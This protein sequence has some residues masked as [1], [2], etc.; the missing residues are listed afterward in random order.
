MFEIPE[1]LKPSVADRNAILN[2]MFPDTQ[3][4]F[5]DTD[6]FQMSMWA[7]FVEQREGQAHLNDSD[8]ESEAEPQ[9]KKSK[10]ESSLKGKSSVIDS[11]EDSPVR[12][13]EP[14][15]KLQSWKWDIYYQQR[16][17]WRRHPDP[18]K[19]DQM[20]QMCNSPLGEVAVGLTVIEL[21]NLLAGMHPRD[22]KKHV[23][24]LTRL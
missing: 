20:W 18:S 7:S 3:C 6:F 15:A 21:G 22:I 17:P 23:Y 19:D 8:D 16:K 1:D 12:E 2:R 14:P 4:D 10:A 5:E 11:D 13:P 24:V 9:P